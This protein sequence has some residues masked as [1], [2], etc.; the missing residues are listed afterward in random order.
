VRRERANIQSEPDMR[1]HAEQSSLAS[2]AYG[3]VRQRILRG[4]I[5][6][7]QVIS[8]RKLAA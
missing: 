2:E 4:E 5:G 8:R 3:I 6:L 7:G 1:E